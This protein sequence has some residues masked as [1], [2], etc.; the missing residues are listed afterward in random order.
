MEKEKLMNELIAVSMIS[1]LLLAGCSTTKQLEITTTPIEKPALVL[2]AA[3]TLNLQDVE[4]FVINEENVE[5]V[6]K[7]IADDKKDIV[8]FGL[9]DDG[10]EQ[11]ALNLSD[12]MTL[13]Q[14]QKAIIGAYKEYYEDAEKAIDDANAEKEEADKANKANAD[15]KWW[16]L[17]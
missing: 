9:T 8:L 10:Y 12:I 15:K 2:P 11:L 5:T 1:I 7:R 16:E 4:W 6:W 17:K 14:Q 13:I 3:D